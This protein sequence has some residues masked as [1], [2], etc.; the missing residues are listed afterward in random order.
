MKVMILQETVKKFKIINLEILK[1]NLMRY[2]KF[3]IFSITMYME[4]ILLCCFI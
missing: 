3:T 4:Y 1:T 2:D